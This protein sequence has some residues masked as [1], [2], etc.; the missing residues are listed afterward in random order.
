MNNALTI[1]VSGFYIINPTI[2]L[3]LGMVSAYY[4]IFISINQFLLKKETTEIILVM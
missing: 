2:R 1:R 3:S 4:L